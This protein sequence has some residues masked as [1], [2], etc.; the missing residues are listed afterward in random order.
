MAGKA[1]GH[2]R[3]SVRRVRHTDSTRTKELCMVGP[4][5]A[6]LHLLPPV[7]NVPGYFRLRC[8]DEGVGE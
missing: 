8:P 4:T 3:E 5:R 6:I 7:S 2:T 1:R